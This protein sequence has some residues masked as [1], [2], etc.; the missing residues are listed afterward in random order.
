MRL[1]AGLCGLLLAFLA[2][3]EMIPQILRIEV[4]ERVI[5]VKPKPVPPAPPAAPETPPAQEPGT[6]A[7]VPAAPASDT[8]D[9]R[10]H[11]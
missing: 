5:E 7:P 9:D 1:R 6:G 2:G 3:C 4:G 8:P 10:P 11:D